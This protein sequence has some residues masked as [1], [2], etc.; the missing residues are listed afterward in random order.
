MPIAYIHGLYTYI[1]VTNGF[2]HGTIKQIA[3]VP[4][5]TL[6][7]RDNIGRNETLL[8]SILDTFQLTESNAVLQSDL[9][10]EAD[11]MKVLLS[12]DSQK[13][14]GAANILYLDTFI[15][16]FD[17]KTPMSIFDRFTGFIWNTSVKE[18]QEHKGWISIAEQLAMAMLYVHSQ[19]IV[20]NKVI[21]EDDVVYVDIDS[22]NRQYKLTNFERAIQSD[23]SE[24]KALDF[25]RL[26]KF[27]VFQ[28]RRCEPVYE[29][30][31]AVSIKPLQY[32]AY[33]PAR[34]YVASKYGSR[35]PGK[36]PFEA[37]QYQSSKEFIAYSAC[38][39]LA[40]DSTQDTAER[41]ISYNILLD[42]LN[43]STKSVFDRLLYAIGAV[44]TNIMLQK[45]LFAA[46]M[47]LGISLDGKFRHVIMHFIRT[48]AD[49][50]TWSE[51]MEEGT[52]WT[53]RK[54]A[55]YTEAVQLLKS[56]LSSKFLRYAMMVQVNGTVQ[57]LLNPYW[58]HRRTL[59]QI[60]QTQGY[61][62]V[63]FRDSRNL[64]TEQLV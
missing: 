37:L 33:A 23:D 25:K 40:S 45:R 34:Q 21:T 46:H 3:K 59:Q 54:R 4:S 41:E 52:F 38:I 48:L 20:Y 14:P 29:S 1:P 9:M 17:H 18:I 60:V 13:K 39:I 2:Y 7:D 12:A 19:N 61:K 50:A 31:T 63:E 49:T 8:T 35:H 27:L 57:R 6:L 26:A 62:E 55:I 16:D 24:M 56:L 42:T 36:S 11:I 47:I 10:K 28:A 43:I 64:H 44:Y 53:S 15:P 22:S 30:I 58:K 32:A 51:R 5:Q